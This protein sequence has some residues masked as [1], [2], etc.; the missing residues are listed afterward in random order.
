MALATV[1]DIVPLRGENRALVRR[2]LAVARRALRPGLRALLRRGGRRPRALDEG[3][4]AFRLGAADQR[5]RAPLPRR[6]RRRADADRR[7]GARRRDRRRARPRQQRAPRGGARGPRRRRAGPPRAGPRLPARRWCS[8]ARAGTRAWSG[9]SPRAWSSATASGR[10]DRPRRGRAR[11]AARRAASRASTCWPASTPAPST[12][13]ATAATGPP[14]VWRSRRARSSFR[15]AFAAHAPPSARRSPAAGGDDRRDR[16]RR[17]P[18]A[19]GRRAV[20]AA[21]PVR[22]RQPARSACWSPARGSA[23]CGRWARTSATRASRSRAA[24]GG[25]SGVA[26]GVNGRARRGR[27]GRGAARRLA[28]ARGERVERRCRAAGRAR[29]LYRPDRRGPASARTA[30]GST[31]RSGGRRFE[32]ELASR[33]SAWPPTGAAAA[34][35]RGRRS[36][37]APRGSRRSRRWPPAASRCWPLRCDALRRRA[38]VELAARPARFGGGEVAIALRAPAPRGAVEVRLDG[39]LAAG[40]ASCSPTGP[41]WRATRRWRGASST[42]WRS[43][44]RARRPSRLRRCSRRRAGRGFLHLGWGDAEVEFATPGPR[45]RTGRRGRCW[46]RVYRALCASCGRRARSTGPRDPAACEGPAHPAQ[47][48]GRRPLP[49]RAR[50]SSASCDGRLGRPDRALR[51][52]SSE[53]TDLERSAAFV[54]Y[55]ERYEEG[56]DT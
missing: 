30:D 49:A 10:A 25:R 40:A 3:D 41:R 35:S 37:A 54:A 44:R 7:R 53:A 23:T 43:T 28:A 26:F 13:R 15:E 32:A 4:F 5:R 14:P 33:P 20:R 46:R 55:R 9:S 8:R 56:R 22:R 52:V 21:G 34:L 2:G 11:A 27:R 51:V 45:R 36:R 19:R 31:T 24:R 39:C 50:A 42:S 1:A 6:R 17:E 18:R 16:R 12:S 48:G 47:P 38:L 29:Q